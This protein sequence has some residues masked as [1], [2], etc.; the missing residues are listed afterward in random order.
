VVK[1]TRLGELTLDKSWSTSFG[2]FPHTGKTYLLT[3]WSRVLEK[4]TV[5]FAASQEISRIYGIRKFLTVTTSAWV[6]LNIRFLRRGV[7]R[8]SP[9]PQAKGPTLVGCPRLLIPFI[10]SYP[11]YRRPFLHPQPED[12]PCRGDRDP[13]SQLPSI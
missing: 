10:H 13:H 8:I 6:F 9:N 2:G 5:N 1:A 7:V 3:P 4:L 11:P 12:A